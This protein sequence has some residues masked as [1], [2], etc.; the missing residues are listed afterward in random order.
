MQLPTQ[1]KSK[2][3]M[4]AFINHIIYLVIDEKEISFLQF[5]E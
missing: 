1:I 5:C 4:F 3:K 2:H